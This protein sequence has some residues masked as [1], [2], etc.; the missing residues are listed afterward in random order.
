MIL[1]AV[2]AESLCNLALKNIVIDKKLALLSKTYNLEFFK[3]IF[4][5][6]FTF[7]LTFST[8]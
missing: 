3:Q 8:I 6:P 2:N 7:I 1:G 5:K 4:K